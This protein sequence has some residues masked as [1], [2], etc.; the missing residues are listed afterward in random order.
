MENCLGISSY[1]HEALRTLQVTNLN[2]VHPIMRGFPHNWSAPADEL[3]KVAVL[4]P[5]IVPLAQSYGQETMTN[6]VNVWAN[7]YGSGRV[8]ATTLGHANT[9]VAHPTYLDLITR[10]LLWACGRLDD[11]SAFR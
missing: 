2:P 5:G 11:V 6:H 9:T 3:Y 8:F 1:D 4:W 7:T 10:G